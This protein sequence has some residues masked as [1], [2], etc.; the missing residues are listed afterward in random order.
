MRV[1]NLSNVDIEFKVNDIQ[2]CIKPNSS[3]EYAE[4]F[5]SFV[6]SPGKRSYSKL[7]AGNSKLLKLLGAFGDPFKLLKDYHIVVNSYFLHESVCNSQQLNVTVESVWIDVETR[8]YYDF[9]KV[10]ADG[11]QIK[12]IKA[13]ALTAEEISNDFFVNNK[14]LFRWQAVWDVLIEPVIL[15]I[16]VYFAIYLF[17]FVSIGRAAW[18]IV[19]FLIALS[20]LFELFMLI[21]TRK[22]FKK[23]IVTFKECLDFEK[24]YNS[25]YE[26]IEN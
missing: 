10:E 13:E 22:K 24:I 16:I 12:P 19:F 21:F 6:F 2:V 18:K 5:D 4:Q 17:F 9:V 3:F 14:R 1:T 20:T 15:Q 23:R 8:A 7:Q 25:C 26:M 11:K